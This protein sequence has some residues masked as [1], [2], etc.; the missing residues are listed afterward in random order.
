MDTSQQRHRMVERHVEA[1]GVHDSAVLDAMR[2]VPREA[3]LPEQ[4][5]GVRLR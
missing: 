5:S 2:A 1:R 3:F 4:L